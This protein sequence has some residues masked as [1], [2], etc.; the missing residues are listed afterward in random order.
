MISNMHAQQD[1]MRT[2]KCLA[3][4]LLLHTDLPELKFITLFSGAW[5]ATI[6][7]RLA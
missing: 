5:L 1:A 3:W 6:L 2:D 4:I 7:F